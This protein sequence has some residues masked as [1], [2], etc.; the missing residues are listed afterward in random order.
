[1]SVHE[2]VYTKFERKKPVLQVNYFSNL[3]FFCEFLEWETPGREQLI[4]KIEL[5]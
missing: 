5:Q 1:M 3:A 2:R 4:L